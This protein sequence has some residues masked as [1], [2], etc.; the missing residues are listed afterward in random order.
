MGTGET[1]LLPLL[2]VTTSILLFWLIRS[3]TMLSM[4]QNYHH[5]L[6]ES[7]A[8]WM[9]NLSVL[10]M[11]VLIYIIGVLASL[12]GKVRDNSFEI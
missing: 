1:L 9:S 2:C 8:N 3:R 4:I 7:S 10:M 6:A 11:L 5:S 12:S